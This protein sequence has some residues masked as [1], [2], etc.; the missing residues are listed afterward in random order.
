MKISVKATVTHIASKDDLEAIYYGRK[1]VSSSVDARFQSLV[2]NGRR[3]NLILQKFIWAVSSVGSKER[4]VFMAEIID[5][6]T[7]IKMG[8]LVLVKNTQ[9]KTME[10]S[11]Y[12]SLNVEDEDGENERCLLFTR[13]EMSDMEKVQ[14]KF[15]LKNMKNGRLYK[16]VIDG[17]QTNLVKVVHKDG[18]EMILR[19]SNTQLERADFRR[20]NNP[21]D[22]TKKGFL[23]DIVD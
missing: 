9:R 15:F 13:V 2:F 5:K 16:V 11:E 23:T 4:E 10:N 3:L 14:S 19:I 18:R 6:N 22:L 12:I 21:E 7:D 17:N 1:L 8:N 20:I